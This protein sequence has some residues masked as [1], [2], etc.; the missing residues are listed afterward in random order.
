MKTLKTA[1]TANPLRSI[2]TLVS[3]VLGFTAFIVYLATG[4]VA[5]YTESYSVPL[6]LLLVLA[7]L[8]TLFTAVKKVNVVEE[9]PF[10]V[11]LVGVVLFLAV[12]SNYI[13]AVVRAIDVTSFSGGFIAT[14][15]LLV[16]AAVAD[17]VSLFLPSKKAQ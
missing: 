15:V 16:L 14:I 5:N 10:I 3:F 9:I 1:F 17:L 2:V 6:I 13:V 11:Y 12:N 8:A 7:L 4:I